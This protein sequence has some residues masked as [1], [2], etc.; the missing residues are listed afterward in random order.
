MNS[1]FEIH[2]FYVQ[3]SFRALRSREYSRSGM[4]IPGNRSLVISS[5]I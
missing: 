3:T 5:L 2:L 4:L 1:G